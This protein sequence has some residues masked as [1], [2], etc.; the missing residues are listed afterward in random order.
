[1]NKLISASCA[2]AT[3]SAVLNLA[4]QPSQLPELDTTIGN[5]V[6]QAF[7]GYDFFDIKKLDAY[8][9]D[10]VNGIPGKIES[11]GLGTFNYKLCQPD[12]MYTE[13]GNTPKSCSD[14]GSGGAFLVKD[15]ECKYVFKDGS[16]F[17]GIAG[18]T[19]EKGDVDYIGY[20]LKMTSD[21]TCGD[22]KFVFTINAYCDQTDQGFKI[23]NQAAC[24]FD[25]EY[26]GPEACKLYSFD[27]SGF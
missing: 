17:T 13:N 4:D 24:S 27:G 12:W 9:R 7:A 8:K 11:D 15:G 3:A 20:K 22:G 19:N 16:A 21:N 5:G 6:C 10:T 26:R 2:L 18:S 25:A 1:M 23:A 14:L